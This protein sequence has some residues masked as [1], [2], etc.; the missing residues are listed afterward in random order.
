MPAISPF[1]MDNLNGRPGYGP[2]L[3]LIAFVAA[4]GAYLVNRL[5][6]KRPG[7]SGVEF[8]QDGSMRDVSDERADKALR[9]LE[10]LNNLGPNSLPSDQIRCS[11]LP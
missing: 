7:E 2:I 8:N 3:L 4:G 5:E 6:H 10:C 11:T 9:R 1:L